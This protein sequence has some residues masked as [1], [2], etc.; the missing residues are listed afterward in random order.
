LLYWKAIEQTHKSELVGKSQFGVL[1]P[2]L[3]NIFKVFA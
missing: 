2:A 1:T 3:F